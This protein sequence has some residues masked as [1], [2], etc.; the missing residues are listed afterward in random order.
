MLIYQILCIPIVLILLIAILIR[1]KEG[2]SSYLSFIVSLLV[3]VAIGLIGIFPD[4]TTNIAGIFGIKRGLDFVIILGILGSYL[5]LY[6]IYT[7]LDDLENELT[8]LVRKLALKDE[9]NELDDD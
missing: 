3:V 2:R 1:Q 5:I 6:K 4:M 7:M 8:D 9:Y